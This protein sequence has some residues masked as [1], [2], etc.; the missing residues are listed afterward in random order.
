MH[1][2]NIVIVSTISALVLLGMV[3]ITNN[4]DKY[5][6]QQFAA[7]QTASIVSGSQ[8]STPVASTSFSS[9][10]FSTA[11]CEYVRLKFGDN[12]KEYENCL[13]FKDGINTNSHPIDNL[14]WQTSMIGQCDLVYSATQDAWVDPCP[15]TWG[16]CDNTTKSC[17]RMVTT[18]QCYQRQTFTT[19]RWVP[20]STC[21]RYPVPC[22]DPM[23][24]CAATTTC[25]AKSMIDGV[26]NVASDKLYP[27]EAEATQSV[28]AAGL[29]K[30][31]AELTKQLTSPS[32][33]LPVC[34]PTPPCVQKSTSTAPQ[35]ANKVCTN[36]TLG[37]N[38]VFTCTASVLCT[39]IRIC[40][41]R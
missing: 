35:I 30:C 15:M 9:S 37:R 31:N 28:M 8:T 12:S 33:R 26:F 16:Q 38:V 23:K 13:E 27:T 40:G 20:T 3:I 17:T 10:I 21:V 5:N 1:I 11:L 6:T 2:K 7:Q 24:E 18:G 36:Q 29:A 39:H 41:D 32:S 25:S 19:G 34:A 4:G 22:A 14:V